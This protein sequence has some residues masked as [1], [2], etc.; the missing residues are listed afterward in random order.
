M[1]EQDGKGFRTLHAWQ[2]AY[3]LTL[4]IYKITREFPK[5][6]IYGLTSQLQRAAVSVPANIAEGYERNYKK[7]YQQFLFIAKGSLGEIET[8]LMLARDLQYITKAEYDSIDGKRAKAARI[9]IGLI[10]SLK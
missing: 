6:E 3:E 10:K 4:D 9:L 2:M 8:Y 1:G 7:E 5:E